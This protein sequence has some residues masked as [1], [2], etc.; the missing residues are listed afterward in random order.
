MPLDE[1]LNELWKSRKTIDVNA[2]E[3]DDTREYIT[4]LLKAG[5]ARLQIQLLQSQN[6]TL[7]IRQDYTKCGGTPWRCCTVI[8]TFLTYISLHNTLKARAALG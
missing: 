5:A 3:D 4:G 7:R 8:T 2:V 6:C 1:D